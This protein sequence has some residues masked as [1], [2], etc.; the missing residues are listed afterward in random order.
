MTNNENK[1]TI[2]VTSLQPSDCSNW[3]CFVLTYI[4]KPGKQYNWTNPWKTLR[5]GLFLHREVCC[6]T[7]P[8]FMAA[9]PRPCFS[10]ALKWH[11]NQWLQAYF[12]EMFDRRCLRKKTIWY[13]P[14]L[15][16]LNNWQGVL[17][18]TGMSYWSTFH[19]FISLLNTM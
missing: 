18:I 19:N 10:H 16:A 4:Y 5:G 9:Y 1:I 3:T 17:L 13:I 8:L 12:N 7:Y 14:I 15:Y 11:Y 2:M 6:P